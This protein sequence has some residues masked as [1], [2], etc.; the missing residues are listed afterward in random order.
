MGVLAYFP[1]VNAYLLECKA[2]FLGNSSTAYF[3]FVCTVGGVN[4]YFLVL[5][6]YAIDF[7][8]NFRCF[9]HTF[10]GS[11]FA[12]R[13]RTGLSPYGQVTYAYL[14]YL[15]RHRES[16]DDTDPLLILSGAHFIRYWTKREFR[17][18]AHTLWGK[19]FLPSCGALRF[20]GMRIPDGPSPD[21]SSPSL[22]NTTLRILFGVDYVIY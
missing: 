1:G 21:L 8:R 20:A 3:R 7:E 14:P 11:R 6:L 10:W 5:L 4:A 15:I 13:T 17:L 18:I 12:M 22:S 9:A 16:P 19:G 2:Y